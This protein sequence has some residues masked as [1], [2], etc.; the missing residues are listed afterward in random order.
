MFGVE[1]RMFG[2]TLAEGLWDL[3]ANH[4]GWRPPWLGKAGRSSFELIRAICLTTK[5]NHGIELI[6]VIVGEE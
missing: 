6:P 4:F 1:P 5:E 2:I 3:G